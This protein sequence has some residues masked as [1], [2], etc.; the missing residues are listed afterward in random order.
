[1]DMVN[2]ILSKQ[3]FV[4]IWWVA[5]VL[6]LPMSFVSFCVRGPLYFVRARMTHKTWRGIAW[7]LFGGCLAACVITVGLALS[8][9]C[10]KYQPLQDFMTAV[11]YDACAVTRTASFDMVEVAAV[12]MTL[13]TYVLAIPC[14]LALFGW[15]I[16]RLSTYLI[17]R[18]K[19]APAQRYANVLRIAI[20][21]ALGIFYCVWMVEGVSMY[22][23]MFPASWACEGWVTAFNSIS[24]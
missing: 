23:D 14:T 22:F 10:W 7:T 4:E 3:E 15:P 12:L 18:V 1:M 8:V 21:A 17:G 6:L 2:S 13:T 16:A 19:S 20:V 11:S 24:F 9:C 5:L